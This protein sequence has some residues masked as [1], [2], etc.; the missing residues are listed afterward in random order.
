MA[1]RRGLRQLKRIMFRV[2]LNKPLWSNLTFPSREMP[3]P[4]RG[5]DTCFPLNEFCE[6]SD[7]DECLVDSHFRG[8]YKRPFCSGLSY[9][10]G[11]QLG[12]SE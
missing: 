10:F 3:C 9:R 1:G 8:L 4:P 11:E 6:S 5:P 12:E 2:W 7:H